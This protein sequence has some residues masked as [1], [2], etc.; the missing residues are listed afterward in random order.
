M[1]VLSFLK[2][3]GEKN[4]KKIMIFGIPVGAIITIVL[5]A[6]FA[7]SD[8]QSAVEIVDEGQDVMESAKKGDTKEFTDTF[9]DWFLGTVFPI[10]LGGAIIGA[11][12]TAIFGGKK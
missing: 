1:G 7:M 3:D 6:Y 4:M 12:L 8:A 10:I 9:L 2:K 5:V 11:F